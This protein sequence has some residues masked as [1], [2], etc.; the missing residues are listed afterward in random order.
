L[1]SIV[2]MKIHRFFISEKISDTD[3][4]I[5]TDQEL[6]HQITNVLRL[7]VNS[8]IILLDNSGTEFHGLI[9]DIKKNTITIS[10][11]NIFYYSNDGEKIKV[12]IAASILKKDKYE[13]VMQKCTEIG[14]RCFFPIISE[15]TEKYNL[16]LDRIEKIV[17]EASEQSEKKFL[18]K[19]SHI[20][21]LKDFLL[22]YK[23]EVVALDL[24]RDIID[25]SQLRRKK[26]ICFLIGPEGGWGNEDK[27]IFEAHSLKIYSLGDVV[28]RA[29]TASVAISSLFL[30]GL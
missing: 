10:K 17:R 8:K 20:Q 30:L 19:V 18:P 2:K 9:S 28:L 16:N 5:I 21:S 6:I 23:G 13:W 14:V 22:N 7:S 29:E 25:V 4:V 11:K 1:F 3:Q 27:K 12:Y 15:K 26:E 24:N